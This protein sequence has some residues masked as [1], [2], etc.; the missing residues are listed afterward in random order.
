[1][2]RKVEKTGVDPITLSSDELCSV[3]TAP[4]FTGVILRPSLDTYRSA[5]RQAAQVKEGI[6]RHRLLADMPAKRVSTPCPQTSAKI[7]QLYIL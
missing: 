6:K 5:I 1:M 4:F 7:Q 2:H 3:D